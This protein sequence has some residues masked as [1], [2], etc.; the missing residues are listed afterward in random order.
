MSDSDNHSKCEEA[1]LKVVTNHP[2][3]SVLLEKIEALG[4]PL[5]KN[6]FACRYTDTRHLIDLFF[7]IE[8]YRPCEGN[9][10]GGFSVNASQPQVSS[11]SSFVSCCRHGSS[12]F[13]H[14]RC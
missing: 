14:Y 7:L 13:R 2:K 9:I 10:S 5:P 12:L 1:L 8:C 6:F 4:C 3:V 11:S